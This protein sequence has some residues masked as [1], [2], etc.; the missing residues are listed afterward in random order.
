MD[1]AQ[2]ITVITHL[3]FSVAAW[4]LATALKVRVD[5]HEVRIVTLE[6]A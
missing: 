5:N 3:G 6:A 4:R 2:L 1:I